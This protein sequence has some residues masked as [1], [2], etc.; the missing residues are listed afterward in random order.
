MSVELPLRS[1]FQEPTVARLLAAV[2][3]IRSAVGE[4]PAP[5]RIAAL[6][7]SASNLRSRQGI[8]AGGRREGS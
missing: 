8:G 3:A 5:P 2:L 1:L 7:R 6:S 4:E